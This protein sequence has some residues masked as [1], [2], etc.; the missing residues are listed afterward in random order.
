MKPVTSLPDDAQMAGGFSVL[1]AKELHA[2]LVNSHLAKAMTPERMTLTERLADLEQIHR[3][4]VSAAWFVLAHIEEREKL[5]VVRHDDDSSQNPFEQGRRQ[6]FE[7]YADEMR[8][9]LFLQRVQE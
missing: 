7:E 5:L 4:I 9:L 3:V 2:M 8:K 6:G 1:E